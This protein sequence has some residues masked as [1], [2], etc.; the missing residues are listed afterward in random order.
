MPQNPILIHDVRAVYIEA[1]LF[2]CRWRGQGWR[3]WRWWQSSSS[4]L[5][6]HWGVV[7]G[8]GNP[9]LDTM[10]T[11]R[12]RLILPA[13]NFH[14]PPFTTRTGTF[15]K[16]FRPLRPRSKKKPPMLYTRSPED[17]PTKGP[18]PEAPKSKSGVWKAALF[19]AG[20]ACGGPPCRGSFRARPWV[21]VSQRPLC[22]WVGSPKPQKL[23]RSLRS[24]R[25]SKTQ[26]FVAPIR[27]LYILCP[28]ALRKNVTCC[29]W[30]CQYP[31]FCFYL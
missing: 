1:L 29:Y 19:L 7:V 22:A 23:L 30:S 10:N 24:F 26:G 16:P 2:W 4:M 12:D 6:L 28:R 11:I 9:A 13:K 20:S 8:L 31:V 15:R 18:R 5:L 21:D 17:E 27:R 3:K 14:I 25:S